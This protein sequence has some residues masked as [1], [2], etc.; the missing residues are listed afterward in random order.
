M[1]GFLHVT[2]KNSFS[3]LHA[4]TKLPARSVY[5]QHLETALIQGTRNRHHGNNSH[6]RRAAEVKLPL[7]E[8]CGYREFS[9]NNNGDI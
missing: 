4:L 9:S 3:P 2:Y 6:L 5:K 7:R 8:T 1:F